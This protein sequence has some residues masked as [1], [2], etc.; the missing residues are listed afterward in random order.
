[1]AEMLTAHVFEPQGGANAPKSP[2]TSGLSPL[3]HRIQAHVGL[4]ATARQLYPMS[5]CPLLSPMSSRIQI[6]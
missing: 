6:A 5:T 3:Q 1:M 4:N 2:P